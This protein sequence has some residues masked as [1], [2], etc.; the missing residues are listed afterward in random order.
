MINYQVYFPQDM[1]RKAHTLPELYLLGFWIDN[2]VAIV[3]TVISSPG[4]LQF[5][6]QLPSKLKALTVVGTIHSQ[7]Y[8]IKSSSSNQLNELQRYLHGGK[9]LHRSLSFYFG[10]SLRFPVLEDT[11]NSCSF[12]LF[13]PPN[14]RNLEYFSINP[15]LLQHTNREPRMYH[16]S[17]NGKLQ[18]Y[19]MDNSISFITA[20]TSYSC[21]ISDEAVLDQLNGVRF[22]RN[23]YREWLKDLNLINPQQSTSKHYVARLRLLITQTLIKL[24]LVTQM[25]CIMGIDLINFDINGFKPVNYSLVLKQLDLRLKQLNYFP[26]QFMSYYDNRH[27]QKLFEQLNIPKFNTNLNVNNS[28]YINLYNS[29]WLIA[30]DI[31]FGLTCYRLTVVHLAKIADFICNTIIHDVLYVRLYSLAFWVSYN[32]P[33]GFK[34]N[35][36]LGNFMGDLYLWTITFWNFI[37]KHIFQWVA[38][39]PV[40]IILLGVLRMLCI[41]GMSFLICA[42]M[43]TVKFTTFHIYCF[44]Y[45]SA[46]IYSKQ[47]AVIQSLF[48]LFRGKKYNVLRKRIDHIDMHG[49]RFEIDRLLLGTLLFMMAIFL[50]PTVF[51]FYLMFFV[52]HVVLQSIVFLMEWTVIFADFFPLFVLLLKWKNSSRLQGGITFKFIDTVRRT[53]YLSVANQSLSY[54]EIF[55]RFGELVRYSKHLNA[56]LL[57][58]FV[59]GSPVAYILDEDIRFNYLM[60]PKS[61]H[62]TVEACQSIVN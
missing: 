3:V 42:V 40:S 27:S 15:I 12:I 7:P 50:L 2:Q 29:L 10:L 1:L 4:I 32:H 61:Y 33:A 49:D 16:R 19:D 48:Q 21:S 25:A 45:C 59:S 8:K 41:L 43:D 57:G 5:W 47:I 23:H 60:L 44:Y 24:V 39:R 30:N 37:L 36:E 28:N 22:S 11:H 31:I 26:I 58:S 17:L 54:Q 18:S 52:L 38:W 35:N 20:S 14:A 34:L 9:G 56:P 6:D 55:Q 46:K 53:T 62:R 51:A 13:N